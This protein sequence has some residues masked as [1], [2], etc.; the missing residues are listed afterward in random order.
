MQLSNL[1][2]K[3]IEAA[4]VVVPTGV[5]LKA[6]QEIVSDL[7]AGQPW[8]ALARIALAIAVTLLAWLLNHYLGVLDEA[9]APAA[10]SL[11][12]G[13]STPLRSPDTTGCFG[14]CRAAAAAPRCM[15][16]A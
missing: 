1:R 16:A 4:M 14:R 5:W 13:P 15:R 8:V 10:T 3:A 7:H 6:L 12:D 2:D 11:S 9:A